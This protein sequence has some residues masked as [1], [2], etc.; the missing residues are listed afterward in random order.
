MRNLAWCPECEDWRE[1]ERGYFATYCEECE[2]ELEVEDLE[3]YEVDFK[4]LDISYKLADEESEE[5]AE[6][7]SEAE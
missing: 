1:G 7:D 2:T 6:V 3:P 4:E 5:D